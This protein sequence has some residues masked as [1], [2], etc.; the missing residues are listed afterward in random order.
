MGFWDFLTGSSPKMK[1]RSTLNKQQLPLSQQLYSAV[2]GPGAGGA[3]GT[4]ADYYRDLL[5][6]DSQAAQTMFAPEMRRFNEEIIPGISEQFAGMGSGALSSSGFRNS[7]VNAGT[8]LQERLAAIRAQLQMQGAQG[9]TG[10]GQFGLSPQFNENYAT[11]GSPGFLSQVAPGIGQ[12]IGMA[13]GGPV[14]GAI[15]GGIG[16]L[17]NRQGNRTQP[18]KSGTTSPY[19]GVLG[20]QN[21]MNIGMMR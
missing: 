6:P 13:I 7:A 16:N 2:Q 4:A 5:N 12:G 20:S 11:G 17:F 1:Q 10:I 14:G 9:L 19:G 21:A 8:D 15:G 3:F 18:V